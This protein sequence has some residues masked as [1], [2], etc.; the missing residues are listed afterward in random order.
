M[1]IL[2]YIYIYIYNL[3]VENGRFKPCAECFR[4]RNNVLNYKT[5]SMRILVIIQLDMRKFILHNFRKSKTL[6][7]KNKKIKN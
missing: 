5:L 7:G 1:C 2:I 4:V 6:Y 3:I